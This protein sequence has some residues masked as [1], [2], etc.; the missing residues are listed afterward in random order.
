VWRPQLGTETDD[1]DEWISNTMQVFSLT[2][3]K[4]IGCA[5]LAVQY[6]MTYLDKN[7]IKTPAQSGYGWTLE[8]LNTPGESHKMFRMNASL[9]DMLHNL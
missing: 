8:V 3:N 7:E 1:S 9:F 4:L 6:Y 2:K 5:I